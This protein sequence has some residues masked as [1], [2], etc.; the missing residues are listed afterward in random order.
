MTT[1]RAIN[2]INTTRPIEEMWDWLSYLTSPENAKSI[3]CRKIGQ[4]EFGIDYSMLKK[5]KA[6]KEC[7]QFSIITEDVVEENAKNIA[8]Y[9]TQARDLFAAARN[10]S[11]LASP[12][13]YYYGMLSLG[14]A[15]VLSIYH[16]SESEE[17]NENFHKHGLT[18]GRTSDDVTVRP[19]GSFPRIHD[20]YSLEPELYLNKTSLSLKELLSVVP[21]IRPQYRLVYNEEPN[22]RPTI[23]RI[24]DIDQ[25]QYEI[26]PI[27]GFTLDPI[28]CIFMAMFILCSKARYRPSVWFDEITTKK[29]SF[30]LRSFLT[31]AE[32]RYPNLILNRI[33]NAPFVFAPAAR[34]APSDDMIATG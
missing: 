1:G 8:R 16:Y 28:D 23:G 17:K 31:A 22:V 33:W 14:D 26:L 25:G 30:L 21:D 6:G 12:I 10:V 3:L 13:L 24:I 19:F 2:F 18:M 29:E 9:V 27:K 20:C 11:E 15:L 7:S 5:R 4:N 32:R 34:T